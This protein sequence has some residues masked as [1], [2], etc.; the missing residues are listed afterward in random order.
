MACPGANSGRAE[1]VGE[2]HDGLSHRREPENIR[3]ALDRQEATWENV[4][5]AQCAEWAGR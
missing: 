1:S 2:H 3:F 4:G 5:K